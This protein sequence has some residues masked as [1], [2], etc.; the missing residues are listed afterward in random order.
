MPSDPQN[1]QGQLVKELEATRQVVATELSLLPLGVSLLGWSADDL[2]QDL[3]TVWP[4]AETLTQ[5]MGELSEASV[6]RLS[7]TLSALRKALLGGDIASETSLTPEE[8]SALM[9]TVPQEKIARI[10]EE[11][12]AL[13]LVFFGL[14]GLGEKTDHQA[15]V[16]VDPVDSILSQVEYFGQIWGDSELQWEVRKWMVNTQSDRVRKEW[17][18][19]N[20]ETLATLLLKT[21][22]RA[23]IDASARSSETNLESIVTRLHYVNTVL[24][25][26]VGYKL[27]ASGANL[28]KL[29]VYVGEVLSL[30]KLDSVSESD[31]NI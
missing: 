3:H 31:E 13:G 15:E 29:Y 26:V 27:P 10:D 1:S 8:N 19:D 14:L 11:Y 28:E 16:Q 30:L 7:T 5:S 23:R 17:V 9:M 21:D 20:L 2:I 18:F 4:D 24:Y 25:E 6:N 22:I 12:Q